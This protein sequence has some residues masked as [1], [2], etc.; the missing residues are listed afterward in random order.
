LEGVA[1]CA[2]SQLREEAAALWVLCKGDH[3]FLISFL[4]AIYPSF[5]RPT[6]DDPKKVSQSQ[7]RRE[8]DYM[9]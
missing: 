7:D 3:L 9:I 1:L 6:L 2:S 4:L 8:L 5:L